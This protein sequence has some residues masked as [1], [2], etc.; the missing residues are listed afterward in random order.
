[1]YVGNYR[2]IYWLFGSHN[3]SGFTPYNTTK[4]GRELVIHNV[5]TNTTGDYGCCIELNNTNGTLVG[6]ET[7]RMIPLGM[8]IA[9]I[10]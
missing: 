3:T 10:V 4:N 5:T 9:F 2:N 1:M 6:G 8:Y 7:Y